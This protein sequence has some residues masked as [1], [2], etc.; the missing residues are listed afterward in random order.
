MNTPDRWVVVTI[1]SEEFGAVDKVFCGNYGG[2]LGSDTWR[3]NS[4]IAKVEETEEAFIF[5][6]IS[7]SIY[8]CYKAS[9]GMSGYTASVYD[10]LQGRLKGL[11]T[12]ELNKKYSDPKP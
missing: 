7:G 12:I 3:L 1:T 2:Y 10:G 4:G 5:T 6:G 9:Y 11:A 8:K